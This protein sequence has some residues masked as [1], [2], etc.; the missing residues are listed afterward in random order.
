MLTLTIV[1]H[2][3]KDAT[4]NDT[5][6]KKVI[7]FSV[8]HS[9]KYKDA[10]GIPVTK[11]IWVECAKWGE[12]TTIAQYLKKGTLVAVTG[13]PEVQAYKNREG[14]LA[15]SLRCTVTHIELLGSKKEDATPEQPVTGGVMPV[16]PEVQQPAGNDD[17]LPF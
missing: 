16:R 13:R 12:F 9:E 17:D 10:N 14:A 5:N 2:L 4:I 11:T 7:N 8:A 15:A 6:G 1:G 3:G